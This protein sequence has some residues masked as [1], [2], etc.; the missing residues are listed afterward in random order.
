MHEAPLDTNQHFKQ[1]DSYWNESRREIHSWLKVKAP[2]LAALYGGALRIT[3]MKDFPGRIRFVSYAVREIRNRLPD[4]MTEQSVS[5]RIDYFNRVKKLLVCW[6][7]AGLSVEAVQSVG[8]RPNDLSMG[9]TIP[10]VV[11]TEITLLLKEQ[12]ECKTDEDAAIRLF[13]AI[14]P[15]NKGLKDTLSP[16]II[17]WLDVTRWFVKKVHVPLMEKSITEEEFLKKFNTFEQ[18]LG[19]L[20]AGFFKTSRSLND[21]LEDTNTQSS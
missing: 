10:K 12:K 2:E 4:I 6:E 17:Q 11:H 21:I 15:E 8:E 14:A 3:A 5:F 20:I 13:E 7:D 1:E 9:I 19:G 18:T 16:V